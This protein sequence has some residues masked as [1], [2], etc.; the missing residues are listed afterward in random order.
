MLP[1]DSALMLDA[2]MIPTATKRISHMF[3]DARLELVITGFDSNVYPRL[4]IHENSAQQA[5]YMA[6]KRT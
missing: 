2:A 1:S 3:C 6:C 4:L 5:I